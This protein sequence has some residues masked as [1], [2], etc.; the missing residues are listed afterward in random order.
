[1]RLQCCNRKPSSHRQP[2]GD[3]VARIS[4]LRDWGVGPA[5]VAERLR[6]GATT[7]DAI[8][9]IYEAYAA[10]RGK[11]R[12]G[13]KT[14][15]YMS[16]L[17]L[18]ERIFPT[19]VFVHLVRDP[20]DAFVSH[21]VQ[22]VRRLPETPAALKQKSVSDLLRDEDFGIRTIVATMNGWLREFQGR[23][24]FFLVRYESLRAGPEENF[25]KPA[26]SSI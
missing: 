10:A 14:P 23:P 6:R 21:Y 16:R 17:G 2:T 5:D 8:A 11:E 1:V 12:W 15:M 26:S 3:D 4:T 25:R 18:L 9:A 24:N 22:L 13:D 19:A 20:R 7:A